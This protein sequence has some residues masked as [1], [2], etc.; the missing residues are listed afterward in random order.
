MAGRANGHMI[1]VTPE[2]DLVTWLDTKFVPQLLRDH[3][4]ALRSH[5]VSHTS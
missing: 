5:T 3:D 1:F 4:L 2:A